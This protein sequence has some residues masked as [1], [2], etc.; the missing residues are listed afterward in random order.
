MSYCKNYDRTLLQI[1]MYQD[2]KL[3]ELLEELMISSFQGDNLENLEKW[4]Q[5]L[6]TQRIFE[7]RYGIKLVGYSMCDTLNK[8]GQFGG[9]ASRDFSKS[10]R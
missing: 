3:T 2:D 9:K 5:L 6:R 10:I 4:F 7:K 1:L 8:L